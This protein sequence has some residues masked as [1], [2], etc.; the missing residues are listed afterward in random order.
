MNETDQ[1]LLD[2]LQNT[3]AMAQE[4]LAGIE[5]MNQV[6]AGSQAVIQSIETGSEAN[7]RKQLKNNMA[8][9]MKVS[10]RMKQLLLVNYIMVS[11]ES[12]AMDIAKLGIRTR[13]GQDFLK[14]MLN[15]KMKGK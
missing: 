8:A 9:M 10:K 7:V 5:E 1:L 6:Y 4:L 3:D 2:M 11:S 13:Q 12:F 15:R 14:E